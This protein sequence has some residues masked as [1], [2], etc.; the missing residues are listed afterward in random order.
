MAKKKTILIVTKH[1][2]SKGG[3]VNYYRNFF[4]IFE[5]DNFNLEWF[6]VGSRPDQYNNRL[7]RK[8][9][10]IIET[11]C[12]LLRFTFLLIRREDIK[13][14]QV[15]P[16]FIPIPILR[17]SVFLRLA[18]L[19]GMKTIAFFRGW[20][21][22][23]EE[24][25]KRSLKLQSRIQRFYG[26]ADHIFTLADKFKSVLSEFGLSPNK[27]EVTR[28]MF[29]KRDLFNKI[30][31]AN[32]E[33]R[34]VYLGRISEPKG[35]LDIIDAIVY[36]K[37]KGISLN[38]NI[39]GHFT[40]P[41]LKNKVARILEQKGPIDGLKIAGYVD[42]KDKYRMLSEAD[43]FVF[44]SHN[45]GCPNAL[46]EAMAS[47]LFCLGTPVGAIDE[48]II[49]GKSGFIVP[50]KNSIAIADKLTWCVN[51]RERVR[52]FGKVN[53]QYAADFLEQ[54]KIISRFKEVYSALTENHASGNFDK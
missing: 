18:K 38:F 29:D 39:Y 19:A 8:F 54:E 52:E 51:N 44:P 35:V 41:E 30:E 9:A 7:N 12:D 10:Y 4:R 48:L 16:S 42:G 17:D 40:T 13:I 11:I 37:G 31:N 25:V 28:T 26:E 43:V 6:T 27:I 33:L 5:D 21:K 46:I 32:K 34:F 1:P 2:D 20:S 14:V 50:V 22:E 15:N 53:A 49:D 23:Y 3:V 45:E 36:L 24:E 47:G